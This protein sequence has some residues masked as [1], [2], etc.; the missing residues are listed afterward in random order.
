MKLPRL[1]VAMISTLAALLLAVQIQQPYPSVAPLHHI[2]TL[3]LL[4]ASPFIL[5]RWPMSNGAVISVVLFFALHTIGGRYTYSNV[6][7]D[8]WS[9]SLFGLSLDQISGSPV[10]TTT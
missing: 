10:T 2:P 5:R 9:R 8:T 6:P 4:L 7:Y 3:I 1:Q